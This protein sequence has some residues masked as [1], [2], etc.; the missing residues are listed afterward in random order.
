MNHSLYV[1]IPFCKHR[2]HYCDFITTA[3][4]EGELPLYAE[5]LIKEIRIAN[6]HAEKISLH[7]IYFGGG[8]PSLMALKDFEKVLEAIRQSYELTADC[9]I[10]LE[11][12]PGTLHADYLRGLHAL[13]F[14]RLSLG[15]QSTDSFDL[16]RLDRI[17]SIQDVLA[18]V[19]DARRAGFTNI[20]LDLIFG[21]PWQ[22]LDSW[23]N[24]LQRAIDLQPEHFSLYALIIEEGTA[25]YRWDQKGLIEPQDQD[26]QADMYEL[27]MAMLAEAGYQQYEI[28]NWAKQ[29]EGADLRCRHNMQY[30]L[31]D[32]YIGVGAGAQGYFDHLRLVNTPNLTDYINR[33]RNAESAGWTLTNTP[34][35]ISSEFVD[36]ETRMMDEMMLGLRLVQQGVGE[37]DFQRRYDASMTAVFES[38]LNRLIGLGLLEWV[39]TGESR[40][41]RLTHHGTMV[42]NQVFMAF[43]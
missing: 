14:N 17:H 12:N 41:V 20:N 40:R 23:Q 24:S 28:S 11:A 38:E 18:A 42:A 16:A 1:H 26:L 37:G 13:G 19:W 35:T 8:T 10:S 21:L 34:A 29:A 39:D 43:V 6:Q 15:V 2:C 36:P 22:D 31:N 7:S 32:P 27:A 5:S 3:G 25:L 9:E 30:W 33:M 4:R